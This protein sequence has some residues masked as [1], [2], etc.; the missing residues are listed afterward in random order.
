MLLVQLAVQAQNTA[1]ISGT[2]VDPNGAVVPG[3][4]VKIK[5]E[6]GQDFSAVTNDSGVY[7]VPAVSNG[8]YSVTVTAQGFKTA[9]ITKVKVDT[10]V[11]A[12]V[13]A[14]LEI[15]NVGEVVE[16]S[17]GGEVLQTQTATVGNTIQGRQIVETPIASRDALDLVALL[18]GT[19][20]V[21]R[22]RTASIN[23]LPKGSL[24]ISIDG[25]DVQT[26]DTRT[27]DGYFT[28]VRPRLD[29]IEEVTVSTAAP[30]AESSGDGAVQINF[31]TKRGTN[32]W[33]GG[34]F[35][36]HR[37]E[38]LNAN[39][40]YLNRNPT[41]LDA[42]GRSKRQKI[43]LFQYGAHYS[44]PI[45][46]PGF[47]EGVKKYDSGKDK[48][49]FFVNYEEFRL[50]QSITRSP[51]KV[52]TPDLQAG[53]YKYRV[54]SAGFATL[55]NT[56]T[57]SCVNFAA[58]TPTMECSVNIWAV[59]AA[60]GQVATPDPTV[61]SLFQKIRS[62]LTGISLVPIVANPNLLDYNLNATSNDL[63]KFLTMRFDINVTKKHSVEYVANRQDFDG[64]PDL[65]NGY[66]ATFPG[67]P[68]YSQS[69]KRN[70]WTAA[71]RSTL[72]KSI[73]NEAR[74]AVQEGGP[75]YF[76]IEASANDFSNYMGGYSLGIGA[77]VG[78]TAITTPQIFN[79]NQIGKNPV[80]DLTDSVTWVKGN[81]SIN[82][83]GQFKR[84]V[85]EGNTTSRY[86]PSVGFGVD[87]TET[88]LF[89]MF[90]FCTATAFSPTCRIPGGSSTQ[91]SEAR[92]LYATLVG[93][94]TSL[95]DTAYLNTDT[96]KYA[97]GLPRHRL[98]E[99][100]SY[101]L[102][103]QDNWKIRPNFSIN[104]G[105]RWQPQTGFVA[106][107]LGNYTKLES[108]DE[109]YGTSGLGNI[110]KPGTLTGTTPKVVL[111]APG[112]SSYPTDWNNFAPT[113]GVVWSPNFGEKGFL[114][115]VF[116]KSGQSV[117]RGGYSVSYVREG[118]GLLESINGANPGGSRT[119]NRGT[120][121]AGSLTLGTNFRDPNNPNLTTFDPTNLIGSSPVFP[122]TLTTSDAANAFDPSLKT[123]QVKS[124]TFGYQRELDR[125]TVVELRYVGN[126]GLDLQRQ[127]NLNEF[128]MIE[129]GFVDE[130]KLAQ[131]NYYANVAA[132]FASLGF[133]YRGPGTNTSPL[134]IM[135]SYFTNFGSAA[136]AQAASLVASN[137]TA[138]NFAQT[139]LV[140]ALNR[141]SPSPS[142]FNGT[143]FEN[144]L[145]RRANAAANGRPANFFY[146]SP[147]VGASWI[148][149]N[150]QQTWYNSGVL[151]VRR[152]LSAGLR[153]NANYVWSKAQANSFTT[154]SAGGGGTPSTSRPVGFKLAKN[155]Q[156]S[157]VR[158][159]FKVD[160]TYD[161]PFGKGRMFDF[162]G[163]R[164]VDALLGGW[165]LAPTLR[166][167]S[168]A[169]ISIGNVQ[170]VGMTRDELQKA[171]K[172]RKEAS[173][174][175]WLPDDIITNSQKAFNLDI[176]NTANGGYGTTFGTGGP[177][178]RFIAP[179]GY[180][181]CIQA[182]GGQC[183]FTN[184]VIY[185]PQFFKIDASLSK[186]FA[187]GERRN[188]ELRVMSLDVLNHPN[189]RVGGWSADTAGA[190][191]C[192]STFAQLGT[193]SAYQDTSTT[194][195]PGGRI[196]DVML[197]IN[198]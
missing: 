177:T 152:R 144:S 154:D 30:G 125:N 55:P 48:R 90:S 89:N 142:T 157:D 92:G 99:Q 49:F 118:T 149:N 172:I 83:G 5:G 136:A 34:A 120:T 86:V 52:A 146:V 110:F 173:L 187:I 111:M 128:N 171:V 165:S 1:S 35:I 189:F 42:D 77:T 158:H 21:G 74:Y 105:V 161:M 121:I 87:S 44:G 22:P 145:A 101:G 167:Q 36:Q 47:G 80:Y 178:G 10:G 151:E 159:Q 176:T 62:S 183:G 12:T 103:V 16:I 150:T 18:P 26:N 84:I 32:K 126:R 46:L 174:V 108:F 3:A 185:G 133:A 82:F 29:A 117:I 75:S 88:T 79:S 135:L 31:V 193:G 93:H 156:I 8:L 122:I 14:R 61:A 134:P 81:H 175:F 19:S 181:N 6:S 64:F 23:G 33:A 2:V 7:R 67:F 69:S 78:G 50:P 148:V 39:Y 37:N 186:K 180:N 96:G 57:T 38:G 164:F 58:A 4:N 155:V 191:C 15:G 71:V 123:G 147:T 72:S 194:N 141:N 107:T 11:P 41:A 56:P 43:R 40:W 184:L 97:R 102:F 104:Y 73:V 66:E 65:L 94:V 115:H 17:S 179:A 198:W 162:G 9:T 143:T 139:T 140:N 76:R 190:G 116:G 129:N 70:S 51:R 195:D 192:G 124:Y 113:V 100:R 119:L 68:A 153:V 188:V 182:Y 95:T 53:I 106:K 137:Y 13:D 63:R 27:S 163:N 114:R 169:P 109:I 168:G 130:F 85:A 197:R 98:A 138:A 59:A 45:P 196:V 24:S 170:L 20:T 25:V 127:Y 166:W 54:S 28:Y 60:N 160:A 131:N 112:E 132:G 91:Q